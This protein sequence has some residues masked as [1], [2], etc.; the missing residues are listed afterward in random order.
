MSDRAEISVGDETER[1][2]AAVVGMHPPSDVGQ[3]ASRMTQAAIFLGFPQF[4]DPH[5]TIGPV[6]QFFRMPYGSRQQLVE[7]LR[8]ANQPILRAL[9]LRQ[10]RVKQAFAHP[11]GRKYDGLRLCDPDDVFENKRRIGQ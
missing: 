6:D 2:F 5:Q 9:G 1:L 11:E 4:Y 3:Q 8:S 10:Y 7:R